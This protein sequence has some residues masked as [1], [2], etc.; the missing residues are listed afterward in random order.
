MFCYCLIYLTCLVIT[1]FYMLNYYTFTFN[2]ISILRDVV[3]SNGILNTM[4]YMLAI[5]LIF[6][7]YM[8]ILSYLI[9]LLVF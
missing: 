6:L 3:L 7:L 4:F 5:R 2:Q 1:V 8:L 9:L